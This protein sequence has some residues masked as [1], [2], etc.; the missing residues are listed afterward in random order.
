VLLIFRFNKPLMPLDT[1]NLRVAKRLGII[2]K[3]MS[4]EKAHEFMNRIVPDEEKK[5]LHINFILH[6]RKICTARNPK[7]GVCV[8]N[9]LCD[10][11]RLH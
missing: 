2:P 10:Y 8:I 6:G 4:P 5:N 9:R 3:G 11:Y 7:C 1:H